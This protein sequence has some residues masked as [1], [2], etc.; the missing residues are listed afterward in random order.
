M[1]GW[2]V[3]SP[4]AEGIQVFSGYFFLGCGWGV[5]VTISSV[6]L[7]FVGLVVFRIVQVCS[8]LFRWR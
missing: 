1:R 2:S 7:G 3:R 4:M 5:L 8:V 6:L